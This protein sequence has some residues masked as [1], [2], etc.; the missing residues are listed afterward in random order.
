MISLPLTKSMAELTKRTTNRV[1]LAMV[2]D[3]SQLEPV[4]CCEVG[5]VESG[6]GGVGG[7]VGPVT[8]MGQ[9]AELEQAGDPAA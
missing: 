9:S 7:G 8:L 6:I 3:G 5:L 4:N 2:M 1:D